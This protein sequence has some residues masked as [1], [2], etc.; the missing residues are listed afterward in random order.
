M[1]NRSGNTAVQPVPRNTLCFS[2]SGSSPDRTMFREE[3]DGKAEDGAAEECR[4][5]G[6]RQNQSQQR[7]RT[8]SR[9]SAVKRL[10]PETGLRGRASPL[11]VK[12]LRRIQEPVSQIRIVAESGA[13]GDSLHILRKL[14]GE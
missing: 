6:K 8:S 3:T 2:E 4:R 12:L 9:G 14:C 5:Y 10:C 7:R 13:Q 11:E 1:Y